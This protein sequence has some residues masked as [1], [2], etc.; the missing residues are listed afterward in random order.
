MSNAPETV[1]CHQWSICLR[2][3]RALPAWRAP[4]WSG[5]APARWHRKRALQQQRGKE[6][7]R[8]NHSPIAGYT[9]KWEKNSIHT[10]Q[11][12]SKCKVAIIRHENQN[13]GIQ[14]R[15]NSK[16]LFNNSPYKRLSSPQ[17]TYTRFSHLTPEATPW[18]NYYS[19]LAE[20]VIWPVQCHNC[21]QTL[22]PGLQLPGSL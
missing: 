1:R 6:T 10:S 9:W 22:E 8:I 2:E 12:H 21:Q 17:G 13:P 11:N 4:V 19:H 14:K 16:I 3:G 7:H 15:F 20:E 18:A 5:W